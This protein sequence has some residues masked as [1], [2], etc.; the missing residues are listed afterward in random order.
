MHHI[1]I[2]SVSRSSVQHSAG[3]GVKAGEK[4]P[5]LFI[6]GHI[7]GGFPLIQK[8]SKICNNSL[9]VLNYPVYHYPKL[10]V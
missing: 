2:F 8:I 3:F 9:D 5:E 7:P 10:I 4:V 1:N 6:A